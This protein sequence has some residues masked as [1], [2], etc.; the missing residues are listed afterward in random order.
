MWIDSSRS[1]IENLYYISG[2]VIAIAALIGL[3][4]IILTKKEMQVRFRRESVAAGTQ[5][6]E[7]YSDNIMP[8][9]DK[10]TKELIPLKLP[11]KKFK[12][13]NF[14]LSSFKRQCS[15]DEYK[16]YLR[17]LLKNIDLFTAINNKMISF[18][19]YF[20]N[21]IADERAAYCSLSSAYCDYIAVYY[22]FFVLIEETSKSADEP[23]LLVLYRIWKNRMDKT[24]VINNIKDLKD[25]LNNIKDAEIKTITT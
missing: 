18:A 7:V 10:L 22:P 8:L 20:V 23:E 4:Q 21:G 2:I 9:Q 3:I 14:S 13:E 12:V 17:A 1:I 5:Q 24:N 15:T 19:S 11:E 6:S 16:L 25:K